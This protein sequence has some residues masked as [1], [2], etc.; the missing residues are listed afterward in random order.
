MLIEKFFKDLLVVF[1]DVL[2][3]IGFMVF[4]LI[5]VYCSV[6][7]VIFGM[8]V[9]V[10]WCGVL[11]FVLVREFLFECVLMGDV[12]VIVVLYIDVMW[13]LVDVGLMFIEMLDVYLDCGG[14]IEICVRKLFVYLNIV[15]YW[16][17]WIIDFIGCDFI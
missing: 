11:W 5:V 4:M 6:S 12:L 14:V 10:G 3:V 9:V 8:N 15:W 2:V 17:K 7:E 1:V 13:F 16:F